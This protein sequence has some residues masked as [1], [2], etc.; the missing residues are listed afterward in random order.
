MLTTS[1]ATLSLNLSPRFSPFT[2]GARV[3]VH[4][5]F[6]Q[7]KRLRPKRGHTARMNYIAYGFILFLIFSP[8]SMVA[9]RGQGLVGSV[10]CYTFRI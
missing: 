2:G 7:M 3:A 9:P 10:H 1:G 6:P 8:C 5:P 4:G